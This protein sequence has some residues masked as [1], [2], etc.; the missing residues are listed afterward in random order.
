MHREVPRTSLRLRTGYQ[1]VLAPPPPCCRLCRLAEPRLSETASL[2]AAAPRVGAS[3]SASVFPTAA[4]RPAEVGHAWLL[5]LTPRGRLRLL[6]LLG[7]LLRLLLRLL[8]LLLRLFLTSPGI[9]LFLFPLPRS[10]SAKLSAPTLGT[11]LPLPTDSWLLLSSCTFFHSLSHKRMMLVVVV[12]QC[13]HG[14]FF[15]EMHRALSGWIL[16]RAPASPA[17]SLHH[18]ERRYFS[19]LYF[20]ITCGLEKLGLVDKN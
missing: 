4:N 16:A 10:Y 20:C 13:C 15:T 12:V 11:L 19:F 9:C 8:D 17:H 7:L 6:L 18:H 14:A 3:T 1:L 5:N 2:G